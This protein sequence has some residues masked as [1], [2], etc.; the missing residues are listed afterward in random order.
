MSRNEMRK[1]ASEICLACKQSKL[2]CKGTPACHRVAGIRRKKGGYE[3]RHV[4]PYEVNTYLEGILGNIIRVNES[5]GYELAS[6]R[7]G[8]EKFLKDIVEDWHMNEGEYPSADDLTEVAI[9]IMS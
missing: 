7:K 1:L 5:V 9:A 2:A 3:Q 4:S 6:D 8:T